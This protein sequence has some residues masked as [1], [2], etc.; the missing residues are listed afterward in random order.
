[1]ASHQEILH[2][3]EICALCRAKVERLY[4]KDG[5][6]TEVSYFAE[7]RPEKLREAW[8]EVMSYRLDYDRAAKSFFTVGSL[9]EVIGEAAAKEF[10]ILLQRFAEVA[11]TTEVERCPKCDGPVEEL[12]DREGTARGFFPSPADPELAKIRDQI[13]EF[14]APP[15]DSFLALPEIQE[16]LEVYGY[17]K[18]RVQEK[19]KK[20]PV[21]TENFISFFYL[22]GLFG[23]EDAGTIRWR[24]KDLFKAAGVEEDRSF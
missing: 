11:S 16:S 20:A 15:L 17:S 8:K 2:V 7:V 18:G 9:T 22:C 14:H 13:K 6:A 4:T 23:D 5:E 21:E 1:V 10:I 12:F 19:N 24:L 3:S